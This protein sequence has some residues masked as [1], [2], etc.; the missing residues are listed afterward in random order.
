MGAGGDSITM[1]VAYISRLAPK[2]EFFVFCP[3]KDEVFKL[4]SEHPEEHCTF[5]PPSIEVSTVPL[6]EIKVKA[7]DP[8][9]REE[10]GIDYH[11]LEAPVVVGNLSVR[12]LGQKLEEIGCT[13]HLDGEE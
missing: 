7:A 6:Y 5:T 4:S 1:R 11:L 13:W 3:A 12:L 2:L 9:E 8:N 10:D